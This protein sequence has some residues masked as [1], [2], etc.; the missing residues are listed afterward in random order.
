LPQSPFEHRCRG[1][2]LRSDLFT[3]E[4]LSLLSE[5]RTMTSGRGRRSTREAG[6]PA[7]SRGSSA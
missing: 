3:D 5:V 7:P 1:T 6:L 2:R 4:A